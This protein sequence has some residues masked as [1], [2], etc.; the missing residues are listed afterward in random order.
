MN[1]AERF[2]RFDLFLEGQNLILASA[3]KQM[4]SL[5]LQTLHVR[6][7]DTPTAKAG[8]SSRLNYCAY[9][10]L[11]KRRHLKLHFMS[12]EVMSSIID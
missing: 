6:T 2:Q 3:Q 9:L 5:D 10:E 8:D 1:E 4:N 7:S 12:F 11:A